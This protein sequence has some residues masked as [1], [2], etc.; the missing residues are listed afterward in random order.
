MY[1]CNQYNRTL[2]QRG[3]RNLI[4]FPGKYFPEGPPSKKIR[5]E[6]SKEDA[7]TLTK[8]SDI[9][10]LEIQGYK[11]KNI[12]TQFVVTTEPTKSGNKTTC[13]VSDITQEGQKKI[14]VQMIIWNTGGIDRQRRDARIGL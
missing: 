10:S 13:L 6:G 5:T 4:S 8:I 14:N 11:G 3:V 1:S 9:P 7:M 2:V 12:D